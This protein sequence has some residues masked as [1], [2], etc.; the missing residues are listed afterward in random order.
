MR[1]EVIAQFTLTREDFAYPIPERFSD[2]EAAPLLCAG[3]I[4]YRI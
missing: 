1:T 4:G 3:A 2:A